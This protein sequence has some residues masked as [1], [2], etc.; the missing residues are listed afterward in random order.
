M[1][2]ADYIYSV[3]VI[4]IENDIS[5]W[6]TIKSLHP[7]E[8]TVRLGGIPFSAS[9]CTGYLCLDNWITQTYLNF[10]Q[11]WAN[12]HR[13]NPNSMDFLYINQQKT[14]H[15]IGWIENLK[16]LMEFHPSSVSMSINSINEEFIVLPTVFI[17]YSH[18]RI[19]ASSFTRNRLEKPFWLTT[20]SS[21]GTVKLK[22][23]VPVILTMFKKNLHRR[24]SQKLSESEHH[25]LQIY[26]IEHRSPLRKFSLT[27]F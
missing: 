14:W 3:A 10:H 2:P 16:W 27:V 20:F 18:S 15:L 1:Q 13:R 5:T 8:V 26:L 6:I 17:C 21:L 11:F 7:S 9:S 25:P 23:L 22:T 19:V 4:S 12:E 24:V